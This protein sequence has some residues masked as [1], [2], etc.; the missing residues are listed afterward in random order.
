MPCLEWTAGPVPDLA[1]AFHQSPAMDMGPLQRPCNYPS[2]A[3]GTGYQSVVASKPIVVR[4]GGEFRHGKPEPPSECGRVINTAGRN[5]MRCHTGVARKSEVGYDL[6][7][8][9]SS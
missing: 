1:T 4:S 2:T 7:K 8:W 3:K 5:S 9:R 6:D